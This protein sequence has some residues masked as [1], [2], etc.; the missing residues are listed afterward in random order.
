M[1]QRS[2]WDRHARQDDDVVG[3]VEYTLA[4]SVCAGLTECAWEWPY[5]WSEWH[6]VSG[7]RGPDGAPPTPPARVSLIRPLRTAQARQA[8]D[9]PQTLEPTHG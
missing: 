9:K 6:E 2:Y 8:Q 5:S 4:N 3:M 7:T 1:W